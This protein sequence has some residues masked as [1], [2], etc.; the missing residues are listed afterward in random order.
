MEDLERFIVTAKAA[1]YVGK[2][3]TAQSSRPG[4]HDLT[5]ELDQWNYRDSYYGSTDFLGQE[6]VWC[7][8]EPVWVMNYYGRVLR[9]DLIDGARAA[10]VIRAS[11]SMLYAEGR[12]LGGFAHRHNLYHYRDSN[13]GDVHSFTGRETIHGN[14]QLAY[15]LHYHGG[16]VKA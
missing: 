11:L 1:C 8:H 13:A 15:E 10:E 16:M 9:N 7:E 2:G 14:E 5:F 4:S 3:A 6:A 12:F